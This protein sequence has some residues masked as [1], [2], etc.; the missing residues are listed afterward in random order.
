M[1]SFVLAAV[2]VLAVSAQTPPTLSDDFVAEVKLNQVNGH[3]ERHIEG[4]WFFDKTGK[5]D[6][7]DAELVGL[8]RVDAWKVTHF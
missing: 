3:R 2:L 8:G 7:F 4:K 6:R 5:R 1:F